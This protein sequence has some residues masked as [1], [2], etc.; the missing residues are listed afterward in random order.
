MAEITTSMV[1][2][3]RERTQAGM[4][5]CKSALVEAG[6]DIDKAVEVILKKG[7]VKAAS[8][9]GKVATEGEVRAVVNGKTGVLVEVNCQTDFVSRG[10]DF[11]AFV[12]KVCDAA[13]TA[14]KGTDL[15]TLEHA[16]KT[17]DAWRNEFIAKCGEN[18]VVRRWD[19]LET[20]APNGIVHSYIHMGGKLGVLIVA[21]G[22]SP[23]AT[24][25]K[26]FT[27]FV[28]NC[29]MQIAAMSPIVVRKEEV[30]AAQ[31]AKQKEIFEGQLREEG[32]PEQAWPKII[33][34]K[35][36]KWFTEVTLVGQEAVWD[37]SV[38]T[39]EKAAATLGAKLGGDVKLVTFVRFGL[40]EGIEKKTD[41]LAAEVA[42]LM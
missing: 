32:K 17:I 35:I 18:V 8:R 38:G 9:A 5:D 26:D 27:D 1:K 20:T 4:G 6:G 15:N 37:P 13:K 36:A 12:T 30:S 16:G 29:A 11:R 14:K 25:S 28:E 23:E 7:I 24:K 21:E 10:D 34:G 3:L 40:G 19:A 22:P 39:I 2:E 41:D 31:I 33:D 42:K